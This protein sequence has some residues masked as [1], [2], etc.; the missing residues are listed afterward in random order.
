[1]PRVLV[2]EPDRSLSH[3]IEKYLA[4]YGFEVS[5]SATAQDAISKADQSKPD[6]II[7][8]VA[9]PKNN[10]VAFL[11]ELRSYT[12]WLAVPVIIYSHIPLEDTGLAET[13]WRKQGVV[14]YLYKPTNTLG[15]LLHNIQDKLNNYEKAQ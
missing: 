9:M 4:K 7:L 3:T 5:A 12:D 11:Q 13:D 10:G 15:D 8:E 14:A 1:M 2:V 6:L